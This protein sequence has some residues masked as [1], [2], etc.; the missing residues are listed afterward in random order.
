[1]IFRWQFVPSVS[2][3]GNT[4]VAQASD[5]CKQ[6][7]EIVRLL[8]LFCTTKNNQQ[9]KYRL[10]Y[11]TITVLL[12]ISWHAN[13]NILH[14]PVLLTIPFLLQPYLLKHSMAKKQAIQGSRLHHHQ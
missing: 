5:H 9:H 10:N 14:S 8:T 2:Q 6:R 1:M 13:A 11:K 7:V 12:P 3:S 4:A